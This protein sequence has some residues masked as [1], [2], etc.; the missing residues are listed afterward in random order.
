MSA[1]Q[2][3]RILVLGG[4]YVAIWLVS[5]LRK[6]IRRGEI[7]LTVVD[8]HN[9]HT[10]HG[11]VPYML[12]GRIQ[13]EQIASPARRLFAPGRFVCGD[14]ETIDLDKREV[15]VV[16]LLD[17]R[18]LSLSYDHLV[19]NLGSVDD[20]T[21]FRGIGEH[22]MRLKDYNDCVRVRSHVLAM[23]EQ[24]D[25]EPDAEERRRLLHFVVAGG[26]YA[27]IEVAAALGESL[28]D[29]TR[30]EYAHIDPSE[31]KVTVVHSG[32]QIL[33]E[34]GRRF[35]HLSEYARA[36]LETRGVSFE[37][38]VKLSS[39]TPVEAVLS[40]GR[41]LSTRSIISC[42]GT[43][44][45]PLLDRLDLPR[46][47]HGR[48]QADTYGR[49]DEARNV[50]AAGDCA[51]LPLKTGGVAPALAL[52]AMQG[53]STLGDNILRT[54][55]GQPLRPY[56]FT[57]M[58]DCCILGGGNA[59]GQLWGVPLKGWLAS[60]IWH[61]CMVTYL[62]SWSKRLRTVLDWMTVGLFGRDTVSAYASTHHLGVVRE[63]YEAGEDVVRQG[64]AGSAMYLIESGTVEVVTR[65]DHAERVAVLG[66]GDHFG[67][68]AVLQGVRRTATVRALEP[69][70][71]IRLSRDDTRNLSAVVRPF[72]ERVSS[73][74][75]TGSA[76]PDR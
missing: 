45:S 1:P 72:A 34:L 20:L 63:L 3:T 7:E 27:G 14:I 75:P 16:R 15:G 2:A 36:F 29:L 6:A 76:A 26:N 52:Y 74:L 69:L 54:L 35:P 58:G 17:G 62:P 70:A 47:D 67:E 11:L 73:R 56:A 43:A 9:Y 46:G 24:A 44:R 19:L 18:P 65:T 13:A 48:L 60:L 64:D 38:G 71:V 53:G 12:V 28:R 31:C 50:W 4:G 30:R 41:R 5:R 61:G 22:T 37:L 59:V 32:S 55:R 39:A 42:T 51:A 66:P 25:V 21:R 33:P 68:L 49:V 40:D 57:G 10:F 23:L 8:R